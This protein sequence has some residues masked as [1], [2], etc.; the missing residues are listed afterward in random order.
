MH[1]PFAMR[2][3]F[4][5]NFGHYLSHWLNMPH[6]YPNAKLPRIFKV[7]WFRKSADGA[8]LW[9]GFGENSRAIDWIIR[10]IEG[11]PNIAEKTPIG[12]VPKEG[13]L[14]L[15]GLKEQIDWQ[16]LFSV[17]KEFWVKEANAI[18]AFLDEQVGEDL[19]ARLR[20][21]LHALKTRLAEWKN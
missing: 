16:A 6:R 14:N 2:P 11:D 8:F 7:N 9:P 17:P 12:W 1:D 4:G 15:T 20:S 21:E 13:S 10:R 18:G 19:P 3:F 5:Y